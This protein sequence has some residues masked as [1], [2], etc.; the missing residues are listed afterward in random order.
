MIVAFVLLRVPDKSVDRLDYHDV[1]EYWE[2]EDKMAG[3]AKTCPMN[4]YFG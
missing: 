4:N 2:G 3:D 1:R